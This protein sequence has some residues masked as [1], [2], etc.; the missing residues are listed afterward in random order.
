MTHIK[1]TVTIMNSSL[2]NDCTAA[3]ACTTDH[4]HATSK[5]SNLASE[6]S[7]M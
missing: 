4:P 1:S 2:D 7:E 3:Q 6:A 5:S